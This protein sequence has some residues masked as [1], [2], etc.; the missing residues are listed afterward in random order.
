MK[1]TKY[2]LILLAIT[3]ITAKSN[4]F[5]YT[6]FTTFYEIR[7]ESIPAHN[8]SKDFTKTLDLK[9]G[10]YQGQAVTGVKI[11]PSGDTL[12]ARLTTSSKKGNWVILENNVDTILATGMGWG[13]PN[14]NTTFTLTV[15]SR[16]YYTKATELTANWGFYN[17]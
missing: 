5:A 11:K 17:K 1:F 10:G 2:L 7:E 3:F 13:F 6:D 14:D 4:I 9:D 16:W 8:K 15:D 12:D